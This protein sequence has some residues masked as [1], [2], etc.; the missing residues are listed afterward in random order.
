MDSAGHPSVVTLNQYLGVGGP[1]VWRSWWGGWFEGLQG[2]CALWNGGSEGKG[3]ETSKERGKGTEVVKRDAVRTQ[4]GQ[5]AWGGGERWWSKGQG[6]R[7]QRRL[8]VE[9][10]QG[11]RQQGRWARKGEKKGITVRYCREGWRRQQ[12]GH[13]LID[14]H[15][16][17]ISGL[18][19]LGRKV[20][21]WGVPWSIPWGSPMRTRTRTIQTT[22]F[23][24]SYF[25]C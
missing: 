8:R 1:R 24:A 5:F 7:L 16:L 22:S 21:G 13:L 4:G 12:K 18:G 15:W 6:G 17:G 20:P 9:A 25:C 2:R 19:E 3:G 14:P 23:C 11:E 10:R